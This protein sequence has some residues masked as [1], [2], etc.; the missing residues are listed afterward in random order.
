MELTSL[1]M[2]LVDCDE[3]LAVRLVQERLEN[4]NAA[5]EILDDCSSG[6]IELGERFSKEE[7]FLPDLMYGGMILKNIT[8]ILEPY[9]S[10]NEGSV[11][12]NRPVAVIGTVQYD[13]HDIGKDIVVMMLRGAGFEVIDLGVDVPPEKFVEAIQKY[14]PCVVGMSLL[15]TTSYKSV[16]ATVALLKSVG[17]RDAVKLAVGGAAASQLLA[18]THGIDFYGKNAVDTMRYACKIAGIA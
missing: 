18:N 5:Q 1:A 15:L 4:G 7:V 3:D 10:K 9:L 12:K 14:H 11:N 6:M 13:I 8:T 17:V 2:A 16:E